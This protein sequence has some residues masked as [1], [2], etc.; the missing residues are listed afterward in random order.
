M[1]SPSALCLEDVAPAGLSWLWP[2]YLALGKTTLLEGEPDQGKSLLTVDLAARLSSGQPMPDGYQPGTPTAVV[3]VTGPS[4]L[5]DM[6]VPRLLAAGAELSRVHA[7]CVS[8]SGKEGKGRGD[9]FEGWAA[10]CDLVRDTGARLVVV[11][12][13]ERFVGAGGAALDQRAVR[14]AVATLGGSSEE[15][16]TAVLLVRHVGRAKGGAGGAGSVS[17]RGV[18]GAAFLVCRDPE[19]PRGRLLACVRNRL[20]EHPRTLGFQIGRGAD[21][22][23]VLLWTGPDERTALELSGTPERSNA[24]AL[25][26]ARAF[27]AEVLGRGPRPAREVLRQARD[28]GISQRTLERAKG[29]LGVVSR[30][31]HTSGGRHW[32]W[33]LPGR[34]E[35]DTRQAAGEH[36]EEECRFLDGLWVPAAGA[37]L[38]EAVADGRRVNGTEVQS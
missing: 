6:V 2:G 13:L 31:V 1:A 28:R 17:V 36:S 29:R 30:E 16:R 37:P 14:L 10:L 21:G 22:Q 5:A 23:P 7:F 35:P 20:A 25:Y 9:F 24:G 11:E 4:G 34:P 19:E 27:L 15:G 32:V 26:G 18:S 8:P 3:L 33:S 38:A 12:P